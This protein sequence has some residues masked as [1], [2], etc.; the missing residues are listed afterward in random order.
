MGKDTLGSDYGE[1]TAVSREI[2]RISKFKN[3]EA[4]STLN[5]FMPPKKLH[6]KLSKY[7]NRSRAAFYGSER[8]S[9]S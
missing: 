7:R 9:T 8:P 3:H 1:G 4:A 6:S 5:H 2:S